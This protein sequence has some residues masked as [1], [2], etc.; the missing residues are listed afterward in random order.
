[1]FKKLIYP[2]SSLFKMIHNQNI[3]FK[4]PNWRPKVIT[5]KYYSEAGLK[6]LRQK[7]DVT[8]CQSDDRKEF[9]EKVRGMDAILWFTFDVLDVEVMDAAGPQLSVVS[10][11]SVGLDHINVAELKRRKIALGNTPNVL[12]DAVAEIAIGLAI[13]ANRRFREGQIQIER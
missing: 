9:L 3:Q 11:V 4:D 6:I 13:A 8:V 7:C 12:N 10:A 1:M 5:T 2:N